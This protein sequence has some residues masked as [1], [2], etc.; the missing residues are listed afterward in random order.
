M[1]RRNYKIHNLNMYTWAVAHKLFVRLTNLFCYF[2]RMCNGFLVL[3][4][5]LKVQNIEIKILN[6]V[7]QNW[8][9]QRGFSYFLMVKYFSF[10]TC[11]L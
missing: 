6:Q 2:I 10:Q 8:R 4:S 7:H 3:Q 1:K 11:N 9:P 5:I